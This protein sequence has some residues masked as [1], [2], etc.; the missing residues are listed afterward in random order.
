MRESAEFVKN[1]RRL[2]HA[3]LLRPQTL[4]TNDRLWFWKYF[5][6][7]G[8][9]P[10]LRKCFESIEPRRRTVLDWG[11]SR[12]TFIKACA[13]FTGALGAGGAAATGVPGSGG[14][15]FFNVQAFGARGDGV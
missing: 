5:G 11:G 9:Q 3:P 10:E 14:Q 6:K 7:S 8:R 2:Q 15:P 1:N 12:R 4:A 13:A